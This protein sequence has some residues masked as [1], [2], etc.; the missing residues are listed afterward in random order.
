MSIALIVEKLDVW[1]HNKYK[2]VRL[3]TDFVS[4]LC[5]SERSLEDGLSRALWYSREEWEVELG[6]SITQDGVLPEGAECEYTFKAHY[7]PDYCEW[8]RCTIQYRSKDGVVI[9]ESWGDEAF[10]SY[11]QYDVLFR[12]LQSDRDQFAVEVVEN[13]VHEEAYYRETSMIAE[14]ARKMYDAGY[15]KPTRNNGEAK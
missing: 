7:E 4:G 10:F 2:S 1:P 8:D 14:V 6:R 3:D 9:K 12:P 13:F 5:F 11:E 15:R